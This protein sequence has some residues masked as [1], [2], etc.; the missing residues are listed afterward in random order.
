MLQQY[1]RDFNC[2]SDQDRKTR[3]RALQK[4][5]ALASSPQSELDEAWEQ[6]LRVPLLKLFSD[7]VEKNRE[8]AIGLATQLVPVLGPGMLRDSLPYLL[9]VIVARLASNPVAEEGEELRLQLLQLL[10]LLLGRTSGEPL[11]PHLPELVEVLSASYADAFPDSKK[12]AC[13]LTKAV[14]EQL[15]TYI[16]PHCAALVKALQP[17]LAHQ[18]SR[19]RSVATE[20][21][22]ALLLCETSSLAEVGPQLALLVSDRAPAVRE[23]AVH[24]ITQL[25]VRMDGQAQRGHSARLLPLLLG[26]LSDEV[27]SIAH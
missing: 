27:D 22:V 8:L 9:P 14:A 25:L 26:A 12:A 17:M 3:Q 13:A 20:A 16:E 6:A 19:V 11:A 18:H 1:A 2:L 24:S 21:L 7:T 4:L 10:Q 23:Q 15:P 5:S